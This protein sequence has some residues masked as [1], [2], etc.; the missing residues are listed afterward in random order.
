MLVNTLMLSL[1]SVEIRQS[2]THPLPKYQIYKLK[3]V[4]CKLQ[5][6]PV[7]NERNRKV[8][9]QKIENE[10]QV[11]ISFL[12]KHILT[13]YTYGCL[14]QCCVALPMVAW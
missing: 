11:K 1:Q 2:H 7:N 6:Y 9:F 4:G 13:E 8:C 5:N 10:S 12:N 3:Q 14:F